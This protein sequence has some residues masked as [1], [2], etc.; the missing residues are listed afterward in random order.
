MNQK[1][2]YCQQTRGISRLKHFYM[3]K[4]IFKKHLYMALKFR[5]LKVNNH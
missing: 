2:V 5:A 3:S 4:L 1:M